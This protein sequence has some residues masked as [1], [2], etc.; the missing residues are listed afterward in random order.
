[1]P[2][3]LQYFDIRG[4]FNT[5]GY[6]NNMGID[7][8][9]GTIYDKALSEADKSMLEEAIEQADRDSNEGKLPGI[10]NVIQQ[11]ENLW[12]KYG[13]E[14]DHVHPTEGIIQSMAEQD[15]LVRR[16]GLQNVVKR[17][18]TYHHHHH[19]RRKTGKQK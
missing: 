7:L 6:V 13:V 12:D 17:T 11:V 4:Y 8:N 15:V 9:K 16:Y 2:C 10:V 1:M 3:H 14:H 19:H 18:M 5:L